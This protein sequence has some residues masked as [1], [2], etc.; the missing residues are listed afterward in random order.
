MWALQEGSDNS[1][2]FRRE[3]AN[4]EIPENIKKEV[5][6][7]FFQI[8]MFKCQIGTLTN[9]LLERSEEKEIFKRYLN[10]INNAFPTLDENNKLDKLIM[11]SDFLMNKVLDDTLTP[12]PYYS[13]EFPTCQQSPYLIFL[14]PEYIYTKKYQDKIEDPRIS[15]VV[16]RNNSCSVPIKGYVKPIPEFGGSI[17]P[18]QVFET[19]EQCQ[20]YKKQLLTEQQRRTAEAR[21]K[22]LAEYG[23]LTDPD[24]SGNVD[25]F[26]IPE[27][28]WGIDEIPGKCYR[29]EDSGKDLSKNWYEKGNILF[30]MHFS[31]IDP[32][33]EDLTVCVS[34]EYLE[35]R[36]RDNTNI[37]YT[38]TG[39]RAKILNG[40][41]S[42]QIIP[43]DEV[44][45]EDRY[46]RLP[47]GGPDAANVNNVEETFVKINFAEEQLRNEK[48]EK[49]VDTTVPAYL[50][51]NDVR[52]IIQIVSENPDT[53]RVFSLLPDGERTHTVTKS[54]MDGESVVGGFHCQNNSVINIFKV[55]EFIPKTGAA[56]EWRDIPPL[57]PSFPLSPPLPRLSRQIGINRPFDSDNE[58][59]T[60]FTRQEEGTEISEE[61]RLLEG[62]DIDEQGVARQLDFDFQRD[63][64]EDEDEDEEQ[65]M[66]R[67][68]SI[69]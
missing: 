49:T 50:R 17:E 51:I 44:E 56:G 3:N 30:L 36:M 10:I 8:Y 34:Q 11:D 33:Q 53:P 24:V 43:Y 6:Q 14:L 48:G 42:G 1:D 59:L 40:D 67:R 4:K 54:V 18:N 5:L 55:R 58:I 62:T 29:A 35:E 22:A 52:K 68:S 60:P 47:S 21:Q 23:D 9:V 13:R 15:Y 41:R 65:V 16:Y 63:E 69:R 57:A 25:D 28:T 20:E 46:D 27:G 19:R 39:P 61:Q 45:P 32:N 26:V 7:R 31:E 66:R 12:K 37:Y 2:E 64:D 38:C